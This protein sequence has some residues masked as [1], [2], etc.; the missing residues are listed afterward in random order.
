MKK[1]PVFLLA[2]VMLFSLCACAASPVPERAVEAA[3][4]RT[5]PKSTA[6]AAGTPEAPAADVH[7]L[8]LSGG[9]AM[10]DGKAVEEFD[11]TWHCDPGEIHDEVKGAPAEY[12]T[13]EKPDTDAAAYID[14]ELYYFPALPEDGFRRVDYDGETEWAYYY[15]DGENDDYIFA[16]LPDL[17]RSL[18]VSMMH[19]EEE[20]A[21]NRVLHITQPGTYVLEGV[22]AGQIRVELGNPD[23]AF[24]D[25]NAKITLILNGAD[26]TC[27]VAPGVIFESA[28]EC[29]NAWAKR[30]EESAA[31]DTANAGVTVI[32][33]DNSENTVSGTNV[34]RMLRTKYK[35]EDSDDPIKTQKKLRKFDAAFYSCVTMNI[36]GEE[37]GTGSLT[38]TSGF[39]GI[40]S[41]LHLSFNGGNIVI[42][43][44]DDGI[45]V[46][47]DDVSVVAFN[48]GS[49]TIHAAQGAEG[50]GVDSNGYIVLNGGTVSVDGIR[51]PDSA[52]DSECG[53]L[54]NG[55]TVIID[56]EEQDYE[57]GSSF[58]EAGEGPGRRGGPDDMGGFR[59]E[60]PWEQ[61]VKNFDFEVFRKSVDALPDDA[62]LADVLA[63]LDM[64]MPGSR[65]T[66]DD[67]DD[68][69][70]RSEDDWD[71]SED[72]WFWNDESGRPGSPEKPNGNGAPEPPTKRT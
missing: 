1:I 35:D 64:E 34:F 47:E 60:M 28:F 41:E 2:F 22:W 61:A 46:N 42:S 40:D 56:G 21:E 67:R 51:P 54:Y 45:N 65:P 66:D 50:D 49:V 24:T 19:S 72:W 53:I 68:W 25:E 55:G 63:L 27:T 29:D 14:H 23:E 36:F 69:S 7:T 59:G 9:E 58:R 26:I 31:V 33:A 48:G 8:M 15:T 39:E 38:V 32:L 12:Y 62:S 52:L 43:S 4:T 17:G 57:E 10:L 70:F 71:D 18:P 37:D 16:T 6:E 30:E 44:Q 5:L 20:A 13:G 11:Y 3:V